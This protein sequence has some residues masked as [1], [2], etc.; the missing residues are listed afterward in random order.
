MTLAA[1]RT[2]NEAADMRALAVEVLGNG[3]SR[4]ATAWD[5]EHA[6][7]GWLGRLHKSDFTKSL[8]QFCDLKFSG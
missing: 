5:E 8:E 4:A 2:G 3:K 7:P 6:V 1:I